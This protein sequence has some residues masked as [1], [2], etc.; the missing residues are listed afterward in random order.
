MMGQAIGDVR[1][2]ICLDELENDTHASAGDQLVD[3]LTDDHD[4][5]TVDDDSTCPLCGAE[6]ESEHD[7]ASAGDRLLDHMSEHDGTAAGDR[8]LD[9][10]S[11]H[12]AFNRAVEIGLA[13]GQ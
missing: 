11:E 12:S 13:G 8:L 1:C 5:F 7:G 3:H 6:F 4:H 10:M 9:H 2:P